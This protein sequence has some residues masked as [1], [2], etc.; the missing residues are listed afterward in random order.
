MMTQE[1]EATDLEATKASNTTD[2]WTQRTCGPTPAG[3]AYAIAHFLDANWQPV[4]KSKAV[5]IRIFEY[6][7][8][9]TCINRTWGFIR[10]EK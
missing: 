7:A 6:D 4:P 10:R 3:G 1:E 9:H 8:T 5:N 2:D